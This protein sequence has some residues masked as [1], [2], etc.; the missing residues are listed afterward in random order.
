MDD[1]YKCILYI[2]GVSSIFGITYLFLDLP[3]TATTIINSV[4]VWIMASALLCM[5]F[6]TVELFKLI[7]WKEV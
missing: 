4:S 1:Y 6:M 3:L 7:K 5:I 2:I